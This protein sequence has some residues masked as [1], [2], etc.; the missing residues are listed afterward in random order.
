MVFFVV[1]LVM[2]VVADVGSRVT[3]DIFC[4]GDVETVARSTT[5][6]DSGMMTIWERQPTI[7]MYQLR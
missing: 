3:C 2:D 7:N 5:E 6:Q 4:H 1:G